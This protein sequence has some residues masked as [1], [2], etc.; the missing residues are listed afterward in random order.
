MN[1][2]ILY[3]LLLYALIFL[4]ESIDL[5]LAHHISIICW[6]NVPAYYALNYAGIF[7]G[8]LVLATLIMSHRACNCFILYFPGGFCH[9]STVPSG[10]LYFIILILFVIIPG[11]FCHTEPPDE[12]YFWWINEDSGNINRS[13]ISVTRLCHHYQ[14]P[15][16]M[17]LYCDI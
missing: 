9:T 15:V 5:I 17:K 3:N 2:V 1:C 14:Q 13:W 12:L 4:L 10:E 6:H 7:D 11:D 16:Q 8:G